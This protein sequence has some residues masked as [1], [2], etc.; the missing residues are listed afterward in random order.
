ME[1]DI[2]PMGKPRGLPPSRVGFPASRRRARFG[3]LRTWSYSRSTGRHR[4]PCG[5]HI[6]RSID[7]TVMLDAALGKCPG[8]DI[9]RQGVKHM[10]TVETTLRG[11]IPLVN[12]DERS[13][14]PLSFVFE[15]THKLTPSHIR[16]SLRKC[17]VLYHILD[18]KTLDAYDLV[19]TYDLGRELVLIV[20]PSIS[21]PGVDSGYF[22][23]CLA[24]VLRALLL[25]GM[26]S[27]SL[28]QFLFILGKERGVSIGVSI[29]RDD[30]ALET[31]VKP[32]L[33][34]HNRQMCDILFNQ[35][36]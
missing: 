23:L 5:Q 35:D 17:V 11:R 3:F 1:I 18:L 10:T 30:H 24:S 16:D 19:L 27:L 20:T 4:K 28:R 26:S 6:F 2:L 8:T 22:Q 14:V 34:L 7:I 13:P 31:Q 21:N 25:L 32:D 12:L 9:K 29:A 36:G 33:L 15:L